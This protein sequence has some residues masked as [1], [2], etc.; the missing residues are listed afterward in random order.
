[1]DDETASRRPAEPAK[2][3][4]RRRLIDVSRNDEIERSDWKIEA[5]RRKI[6]P[7]GFASAL[8][9]TAVDKKPPP[10]RLDQVA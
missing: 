5:Q 6:L 1:M 3:T 8:E 9:Q 10:D 2:P 4:K 7:V